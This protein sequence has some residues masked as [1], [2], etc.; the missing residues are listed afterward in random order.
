[1]CVGEQGAELVPRQLSS[2]M[3][4]ARCCHLCALLSSMSLSKEFADL[5]QA[6]S[7][8]ELARNRNLKSTDRDRKGA[9][10]GWMDG[11]MC[12]LIDRPT[13]IE[14]GKK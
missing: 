6:A 2:W 1:M 14:S 7:K 10:D 3:L 12:R 11:W 4:Q 8:A 9:W 5:S 13:D